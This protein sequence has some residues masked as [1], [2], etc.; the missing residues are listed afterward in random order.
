LASAPNRVF[1]RRLG[2]VADAGGCHQPQSE[3][4]MFDIAALAFVAACF[5]FI[6]V[7]LWAL[8]RV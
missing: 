6:F 8:E 4:L 3:C 1:P 7:L 5:V 2:E